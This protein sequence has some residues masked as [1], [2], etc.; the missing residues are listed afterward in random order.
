MLK[1]GFSDSGSSG[2]GQCH[3][4]E[5]NTDRH[6]CLG[7]IQPTPHPVSGCVKHHSNLNVIDLT[8]DSIFDLR[9]LLGELLIKM[10]SI[11]KKCNKWLP[12]AFIFSSFSWQ[13][14]HDD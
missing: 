9:N 7:Y 5:P 12:R 1:P 8:G 11:P 6:I 2:K 14:C 3:G 13:A 4:I 10:N